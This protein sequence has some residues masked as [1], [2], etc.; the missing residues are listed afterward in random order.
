MAIVCERNDGGW[1]SLSPGTR[2]ELNI[3]ALRREPAKHGFVV[4]YVSGISYREEDAHASDLLLPVIQ[5][6][7]YLTVRDARHLLRTAHRE[8]SLLT[9]ASLRGSVP[10]FAVV[11]VVCARST[12]LVRLVVG[13]RTGVCTVVTQL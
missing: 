3:V 6:S 5:I 1:P 7:Y 9:G 13:E 10:S 11:A 12:L 8:T 4:P 2:D